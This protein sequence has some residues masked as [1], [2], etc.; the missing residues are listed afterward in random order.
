M[1]PGCVWINSILNFITVGVVLVTHL[2]D[3]NTPSH[4]TWWA[5]MPRYKWLNIFNAQPLSYN[6]TNFILI[7]LCNFHDCCFCAPH[8]MFNKNNTFWPLNIKWVHQNCFI[9]S[10]W[11]IL[12]A[13]TAFILPP[14]RHHFTFNVLRP[15]DIC[16][17]QCSK[18]SL[19]QIMICC[20]SIAK[21]YLYTAAHCAKEYV[22]F[23]QNAVLF[24]WS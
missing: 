8:P 15:S 19:F 1:S 5:V 2:S 24:L 10:Q 23:M 17:H 20:L 6:I 16:M 13:F 7:Y 11:I 18:T 14:M 9:L 4:A 22:H 21:L 3:T 12:L